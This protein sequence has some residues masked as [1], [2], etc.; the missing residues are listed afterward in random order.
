M[1][2]QEVQLRVR[3]GETDQ[4]GY[5]YHGNY[6]M[7][8]EVARVE[9]LR[10]LGIPYKT[11]EKTGIGMP[12][13]SMQIKFHQPA[14]YDD[15]LSIKVTIPTKPRARIM[16]LYEVINENGTLINSA[17]TELVFINLKTGRPTRIPEAMTTLLAPHFH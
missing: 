2:T 13:I 14:R 11:M 8:Y 12:V 15:L 7:Y 16:F 4:M 9:A 17:E 10:M 6:A 5:V 3:Y 1:Y